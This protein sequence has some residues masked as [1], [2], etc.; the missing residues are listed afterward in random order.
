MSPSN[1]TYNRK[2][3]NNYTGF[4]FSPKG[5]NRILSTLHF[6]K[7]VIIMSQTDGILIVM[8]YL[9]DYVA[10]VLIGTV[11]IPYAPAQL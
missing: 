7:S 5:T 3:H 1:A 8:S 11:N 4:V 10:V 9:P 6:T 2:E